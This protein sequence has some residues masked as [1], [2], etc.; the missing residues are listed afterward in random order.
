MKNFFKEN[1][2]NLA[3]T[4]IFIC[5]VWFMNYLPKSL[6]PFI[7]TWH[8]IVVPLLFICCFWSFLN[9]R[10]LKSCFSRQNVLKKCFFRW[11]IFLTVYIV[12]LC[13]KISV[14]YLINIYIYLSCVCIYFI[15]IYISLLF[16][17]LVLLYY[18]P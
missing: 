10:V 4:N 14:S 9:P 17:D 16:C 1:V 2:S 13:I 15:Y 5:I 18:L 12:P 11:C 3:F 8:L 6:L 7:L